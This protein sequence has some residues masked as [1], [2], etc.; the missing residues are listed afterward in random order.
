MVIGIA[1]V[2]TFVGLGSGFWLLFR[3]TYL[4]LLAVAAAWV[5]SWWNSR[6]LQGLVERRT[7][8]AQVGQQAVEVI[9]VRN[10]DFLPKV[11]VEIED[12]SGLPNHRSRRVVIIPPR[13]N[14]YWLVSTPLTRRGL[15]DWG[16]LRITASDGTFD[17]NELI[18]FE[19]MDE[20]IDAALASPRAVSDMAA[21][22]EKGPRPFGSGPSRNQL[23]REKIG[24]VR[25]EAIMPLAADRGEGA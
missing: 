21:I 9:E 12:P 19:Q 22:N 5:I 13:R 14:R 6:N 2:S 25:A 8:R 11:W 17:H 4:L 24:G 10:N 20:A 18:A 16:P 3:L 7:T 1:L 15:Y 23:T